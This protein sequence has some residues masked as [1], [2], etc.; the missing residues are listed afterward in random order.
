MRLPQNPIFIVGYPRSGTTLLQAMLATQ[1]RLYS[2]PET[3]YFAA[4]YKRIQTDDQG[5]IDHQ[6]LA[7]VFEKLKEKVS[8]ELTGPEGD[9]IV[10]MAHGKRLSPKDLFETIV[11]RFLT[12]QLQAPTGGQ[13]FRWIEKTPNHVYFLDRILGF[14]PQ[15]QFVNIIRNPVSAIQSRKEKFPFNRQTPV[16]TLAEL[17]VKSVASAEDFRARHPAKLIS[18]RYEDLLT[19]PA[20]TLGGVC[21]FL[22]VGFEPARVGEYRT[23]SRGLI[24][25]WETWKTDVA[26]RAVSPPESIK[27]NKMGLLDLLRTQS[28]TGKKMKEYHYRISMPFS[29]WF[30]DLFA[31]SRDIE[32]PKEDIRGVHTSG[33]R[34][35]PGMTEEGWIPGQARNDGRALDSGSGPEPTSSP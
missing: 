15:A 16:K 35:K 30:Y 26:S 22:G 32:A 33:F 8:L 19:D 14:Y 12:V 17:W 23:V 20:K 11:S 27:R 13:P 34:V 29:Q 3:H 21:D 7:A 10:S 31:G 5:F 4:V 1:D 2:F 28:I 25:P 6:C 24:H 18:L 9:Q